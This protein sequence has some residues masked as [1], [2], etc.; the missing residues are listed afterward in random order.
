MVVPSLSA[1]L[2]RARAHFLR[3]GDLHGSNLVSFTAEVQYSTGA[4]TDPFLGAM[5]GDQRP[6]LG[7]FFRGPGALHGPRFT[8]EGPSLW[9]YRSD[10]R[11]NA[12][13]G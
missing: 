7:V 13:E 5:L 8:Q 9:R 6:Q 11:L 10:Q 12:R 2:P 4:G 3:D 1:L